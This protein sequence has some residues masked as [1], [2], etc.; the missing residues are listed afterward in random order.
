MEIN[1]HAILARVREL[2]ARRELLEVGFSDTLSAFPDE[3][4]PD[5]VQHDAEIMDLEKRIAGWQSVQAIYNTSVRVEIED[6]GGTRKVALDYL[7]NLVGSYGRK[8]KRWRTAAVGN[9]RDRYYSRELDVRRADE[10]VKRPT[11]PSADIHSTY[12]DAQRDG[13][14]IREAIAMANATSMQLPPE[15]EWLA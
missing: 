6:T 14:S 10:I 2:M 7:I 9:K 13:N 8:S 12:L 11:I 3:P 15:Y 5:P 1:G 4:Q